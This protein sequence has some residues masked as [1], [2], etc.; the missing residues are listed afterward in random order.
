VSVAEGVAARKGVRMMEKRGG[1]AERTGKNEIEAKRGI[2]SQQQ[3]F[4]G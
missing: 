3:T 1:G 4:C 2:E